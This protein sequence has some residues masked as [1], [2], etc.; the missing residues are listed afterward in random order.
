MISIAALFPLESLLELPV[1]T[2]SPLLGLSSCAVFLI[3]GG[4]LTGWFYIQAVALFLTTFAMARWPDVAHII[5][6]T[7]SALCFFIPG[8]QYHRR[9]LRA[10]KQAELT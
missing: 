4:M 2:L 9:K 6:G 10:E 1:L 8:W 7:V 5:F 3:K